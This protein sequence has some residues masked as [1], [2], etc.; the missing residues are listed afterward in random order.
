MSKRLA[1]RPR[2]SKLGA[3]HLHRGDQAATLGVEYL[4][5]HPVEHAER[6][7]DRGSARS[8]TLSEYRIRPSSSASRWTR[9]ARA[10][11]SSHPPTSLRTRESCDAKRITASRDGSKESGAR[12][13]SRVL[14]SSDRRVATTLAAI[15][16]AATAPPRSE[17]SGRARD[18]SGSIGEPRRRAGGTH[19]RH[20]REPTYNRD[21]RPDILRGLA[22]Q[23]PRPRSSA[24]VR[25]GRC[26]AGRA[27]RIARRPGR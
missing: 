16:P 10:L 20:E 14:D 21:Q 24:P 15:T 7:A 9:T 8:G 4:C 22:T 5:L 12:T 6:R 17:A 2:E 1:A 25:P 26:P 23:D 3:H 27:G 11:G 19:H 18:A 13:T